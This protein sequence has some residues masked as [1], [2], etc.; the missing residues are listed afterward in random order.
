M[1]VYGDKRPRQTQEERRAATRQALIAAGRE[2][3][4]AR[5]YGDASTE[6]IV[7]RAAVTRGALYHHF[8]DKQDL[9]RA[10]VESIEGEISE[11]VRRAALGAADPAAAFAAGIDAFLDA[12]MLP[13]MRQILLLDGPAALGWRTWHALEER[14]ALAEIEQGVRSLMA[15]DVLAEQPPRPLAHLIHGALIEAG[16]FIAAADDPTEA[17][18]EIGAGFD[19]LLGLAQPRQTTGGRTQ[20]DH[21]DR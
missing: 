14:Y 19:R 15:A 8:T 16:L 4:A 21:T 11:R 5:G 1:Y 3:F 12:C 20:R 17:R 2:V 7:R 9:F 10:V 6:E 13:D 18:R